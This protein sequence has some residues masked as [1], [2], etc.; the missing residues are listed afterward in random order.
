MTELGT[1]NLLDRI[2]R[3]AG[4]AAGDHD[5]SSPQTAYRVGARERCV[6]WAAP[7][8]GTLD[9]AQYIDERPCLWLQERMRR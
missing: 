8:L 1:R 4:H 5:R 2:E 6:E 7:F 9:T 3:A